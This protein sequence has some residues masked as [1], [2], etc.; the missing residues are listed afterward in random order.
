MLWAEYL[1]LGSSRPACHSQAVYYAIQA[2][3]RVLNVEYI[4]VTVVLY[5]ETMS[6]LPQ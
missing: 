6:N 1:F 5:F 3:V 4:L 2:K